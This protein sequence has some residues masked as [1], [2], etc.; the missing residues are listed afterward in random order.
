V[1]RL[2][3]GG[4]KPDR[5]LLVVMHIV[6]YLSNIEELVVVVAHAPRYSWNKQGYRLNRQ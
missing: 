3:F 6:D 4:S 1:V 2:W 5:I